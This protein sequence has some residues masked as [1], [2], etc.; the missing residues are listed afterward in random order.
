MDTSV[1][2]ACYCPE[3]LST[4]SES[5]VRRLSEPAISPFVELEFSSA[6]AI[7]VGTGELSKSDGI[8][9][10]SL[11]RSHIAGGIFLIIPVETSHFDLAREWIT[12]FDSPLRAMDALHLAAAF[13]NSLPILTADIA[14]S[15]IAR[16]LGIGC[17]LIN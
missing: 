2:V 4:K 9:I 8:K 3:K 1:L 14:Q 6:L 13:T 10:S 16:S 5:V 7:K 15:R 12:R 17:R 11:F